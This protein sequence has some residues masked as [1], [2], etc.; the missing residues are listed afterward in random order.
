[1]TEE[2]IFA[3]A[4]DKPVDA[5]AE[6]LAEACGNDECT[7]RRSRWPYPARCAKDGADF[8]FR[9]DR[10]PSLVPPGHRHPDASTERFGSP[11]RAGE[12]RQAWT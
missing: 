2:T 6:Y 4:F 5:R 11:S 8:I 10:S 9:W 12:R 3:T 7:P 1:M